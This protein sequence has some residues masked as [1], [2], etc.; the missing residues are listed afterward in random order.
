MRFR[1]A[2]R[3]SLVIVATVIA[4][5][6]ISNIVLGLRV[7]RLTR[8]VDAFTE[9]VA[10][11]VET[12][13]RRT[14]LL[15]ANQRQA[16]GH[17]AEVRELLNL[18]PGR[19]RFELPGRAAHATTSPPSDAAPSSTVVE[20]EEH[21]PLFFAAIDRIAE[22]AALQDFERRIVDEL[23]GRLEPI[24][25]DAHRLRYVGRLHW[26]I[27][28]AGASASSEPIVTVTA[29]PERW[30]ISSPSGIAR[31]IE[32]DP[33]VRPATPDAVLT[34]V[35]SRINREA[36]DNRLFE[37]ARIEVPATLRENDA[38]LDALAR[39]ELAIGAVT[40]D[41]DGIRI[42]IRAALTAEE[43]FAVEVRRKPFT[44]TVDTVETTDLG[45]VSSLV[46]RRLDRVDARTADRQS[47][48]SA[49]ASIREIADD[50]GFSEFLASRNLRLVEE[51]RDGLDFFYFDIVYDDA[52]RYG[53]F[54]VQ[55][56]LG[57]IYVTDGDGVVLTT[58]TRVG[59]DP[60]AL[61]GGIGA[62]EDSAAGTSRELPDA[63]PPGFRGGRAESDGT[64]IL[65]VG[66]HENKADSIM[67]VHLSP[68]RE[69]SMI[70]I[71]RD[72]WW[73]G[74][75]LGYHNEVHGTR[76]LALQVEEITGQTIDGWIAIDMYAFIEVVDLL[77]GIEVTLAEPLV[78]PTYRVRE[79]GRW[80]TLFYE[81]GTHRLGGVEA[82]RLARSRHTSN[83]FERSYRQ[84]LILEALRTRLN[85]LNAGDLD[86]VYELIG[87]AA[88]YV[89]SSYTNWELA[90]FYLAYRNARIVNRTGLTFDN[91]LYNT[92]SNLYLQSLEREEVDDEFYLGAWIL[93]PRGDDWN[94][95]AWFV[96]ENLSAP[97]Q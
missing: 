55:K 20:A 71:P 38:V 24:L 88:E 92:W 48:E 2:P 86:R 65:L 44:V 4:T 91:V 52:T 70:S 51:L 94:V 95:I 61:L 15:E 11:E 81:A 35:S 14:T 18:S 39:R 33:A 37:R 60:A 17:L 80:S 93:L 77:G 63:F 7:G 90:Q 16:T 6:L 32:A 46:V 23:P 66:V 31:H 13:H 57:E 25:T 76:H 49:I 27:L 59:D 40:T 28:S 29:T 54:A 47:V 83:D 96:E 22:E 1:L 73:G 53:S 10:A 34:E 43:V 74:R 64:N 87:T 3:I 42:P 89:S 9:T 82:L 26:W 84:Q 50:R 79:A 56:E 21:V 30:S 72:I 69:V 68:E 67:F 58:L 97:P 85:E 19:Y 78:D 36:R 8:R 45:T 5:L 62:A 75:K 12:Q 41:G